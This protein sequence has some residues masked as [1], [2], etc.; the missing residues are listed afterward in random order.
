MH[1]AP[2]VVSIDNY[3][4]IDIITMMTPIDVFGFSFLELTFIFLSNVAAL[5]L[6]A[7]TNTSV[8]QPSLVLWAREP[9]DGKGPLVFDLRFVEPDNKDVGLALANIQASQSSEF[10][11]VHV[12][13]HSLG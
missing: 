2:T 4:I 6:T 5:N 11:N 10:G 12:V 3:F 1:A 7:Q 13:F 9:S 8:G